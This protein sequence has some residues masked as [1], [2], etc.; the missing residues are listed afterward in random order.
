VPRI[1]ITGSTDGLGRA[2]AGVLMGE[3][4]DVSNYPAATVTGG[5]WYHRRRQTPAPEARDPAFQDELMN[6]LAT[7]TGL[8]LF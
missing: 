3:G 2:A 8:A 7:L 1:L 6:R 5:Y 4:H